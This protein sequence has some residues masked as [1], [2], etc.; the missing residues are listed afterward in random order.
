MTKV[1]PKFIDYTIT[2]EG[3]V[4]SRKN[5]IWLRPQLRNGYLKVSLYKQK[6]CFQKTIHRL[7]LETFVGTCPK[8]MQ[9][10]HLDGNRQNNKLENLCWG[11]V[12]ENRFDSIRHGT[13]CAGEKHG[14]AKLTPF[15]V[16]MIRNWYATGLVTYKELSKLFDVSDTNIGYIVRKEH[17]KHV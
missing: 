8:G 9:C 17:W 6:L 14:M 3:Y 1:I 15:L 12:L 5:C 7:V 2:D 4:Y 13:C 16:R 10:R 11:T